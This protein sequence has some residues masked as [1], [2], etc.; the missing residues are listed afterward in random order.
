[1]GESLA[2]I[3]RDLD[4][5]GIRTTAGNPFRVTSL[6]DLLA[7][8]RISGRREHIPRDSY[9]G[10]ARPLI[11]EI[12]ADAV[13]PAI[14]AP[15]HSDQLRALLSRSER[16]KSSPANGRKYMLSGILRCERCG[17]GMVGRPRSGVPRYVCPNTP[18]GN[19]C[20]SL[21]TNAA[22]T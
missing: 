17:T 13:W 20:G 1:T 9:K 2:S 10:K 5:R 11:G 21:A 3:V 15:E 14:I 16:L 7:S 18:G 6:R 22:S 12:V 8:A 4:A 19:S